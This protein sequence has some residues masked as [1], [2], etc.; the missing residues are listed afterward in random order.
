MR[1]WVGM[2]AGEVCD[3]GYGWV[4]EREIWWLSERVDGEESGMVGG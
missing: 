3:P 4:Q 2:R 1:R